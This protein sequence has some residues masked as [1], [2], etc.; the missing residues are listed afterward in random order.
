MS[1][2]RYRPP[3]PPTV[4][5]DHVRA[6]AA[7]QPQQPCAAPDDALLAELDDLDLQRAVCR[8]QLEVHQRE[9]QAYSRA[10]ES[11]EPPARWQVTPAVAQ[12][13]CANLL[14]IAQRRRAIAE[15][16]ADGGLPVPKADP[17][18]ATATAPQPPVA[19]IAA[20]GR[21]GV[22][23]PPNVDPRT[24]D[25]ALA[26]I[27]LPTPQGPSLAELARELVLARGAPGDAEPARQL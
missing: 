10:M 20:P 19:S 27:R 26:G 14:R 24:V 25:P 21:A 11:G 22:G 3:Q 5:L 1:N 8:A 7:V 13:A 17:R 15:E 2:R 23:P 12:R 6:P 4:A 9:M 16:L 18:R